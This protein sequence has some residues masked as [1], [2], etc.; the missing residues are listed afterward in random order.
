MATQ[1]TGGGSTVSFGNTPQANADIFSFTEDASNILILNVLA[2]DLGGA[3]K[4]ESFQ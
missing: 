3:A 1:T 2:N 4:T